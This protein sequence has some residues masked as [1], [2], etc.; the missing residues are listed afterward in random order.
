[1]SDT[2]YSLADLVQFS[3]AE[4]PADFVTAFSALLAPKLEA[5]VDDFKIQLAA[6][7]FNPLSSD[8]G[9]E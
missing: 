9:E 7:M 6:S 4:K 1:M 3:S 8:E 2:T 5:A